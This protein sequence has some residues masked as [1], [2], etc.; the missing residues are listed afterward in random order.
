MPESSTIA[1][2]PLALAAAELL[3]A[4]AE[5]S[6]L[7]LASP[8]LRRAPKGDGHP[9]LVLPGFAA[10]DRSTRLLRRYLSRLGYDVHA[11]ELGRNLDRRS[12]GQSGERL[13]DRIEAIRQKAGRKISLVGWSLGGVLA[14]EAAHKDP[15]SIR[16]VITLGSP[17][18]CEPRAIRVSGLFERLTRQKLD[19]AEMRRRMETL[20][21]VP[22]AS[23]YSKTDGIVSWRTCVEHKGERTDNIEVYGSHCGL[24][25]NP[26]VL[27]AVADRLALVEDDWKPFER[28]GWRAAFYPSRLVESSGHPYSAHA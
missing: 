6:F 18:K 15:G 7:P 20:P 24:A 28:S 19:S 23:I 27:Y 14:R 1:P 12:T 3:R 9:V 21:P 2:P 5:M 4:M 10:N 22:Y 25:V 11:W 17:V 8:I 13:T 26:A 16:Q